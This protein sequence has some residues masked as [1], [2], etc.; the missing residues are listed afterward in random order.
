[1]GPCRA[2]ALSLHASHLRRVEREEIV[3][4]NTCLDLMAYNM[5]SL[6]C[7]LLVDSV[8]FANVNFNSLAP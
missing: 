4:H 1:M 6:R 8:I 3:E 7:A 5:S 2:A